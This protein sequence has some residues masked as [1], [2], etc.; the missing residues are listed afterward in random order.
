MLKANK[1]NCLYCRL[2]KNVQAL[3]YNKLKQ[4][5]VEF[6]KG[7]WHYVSKFEK[8]K[9]VCKNCGNFAYSGSI[10]PDLFEGGKCKKPVTPDKRHIWDISND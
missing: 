10:M 7:R 1:F 5:F 9:Y 2:K 4:R 3:G 8:I 6:S